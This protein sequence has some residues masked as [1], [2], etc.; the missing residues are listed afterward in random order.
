MNSKTMQDKIIS[1]VVKNHFPLQNKITLITQHHGK[2]SCYLKNSTPIK[3]ISHGNI[4]ACSITELK[5]NH[6]VIDS[7]ES[8]ITFMPES[9]TA[10]N[11]LH[12]LLE[13]CRYFIPERSPNDRIFSWIINFVALLHAAQL[14]NCASF[15]SIKKIYILYFFELAGATQHP[16]D[17]KQYALIEKI[18]MLISANDFTTLN[19][20]TY[21]E[22]DT[23]TLT[24]SI[25]KTLQEHPCFI[26]FKTIP[27]V[28]PS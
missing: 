19:L 10:I 6:L 21:K 9:Q 2:I 26:H 3:N 14:K 1:F 16:L 17:K 28:Y 20:L 27:F 8:I 18:N 7:L 24:N 4:V 13:L 22:A 5:N 12:H 15:A 25:V 23:R 11:W